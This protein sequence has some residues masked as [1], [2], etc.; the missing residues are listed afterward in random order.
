MIKPKTH[1]QRN[2]E[3]KQW[4]EKQIYMKFFRR[5]AYKI[6]GSRLCI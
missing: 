4:E 1:E 3:K 2:K 5:P 6:G